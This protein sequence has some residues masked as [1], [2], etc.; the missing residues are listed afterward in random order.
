MK[1]DGVWKLS[2]AARDLKEIPMNIPGDI[3]ATLLE[4]KI[5]PDPFYATNEEPIQWVGEQEWE[6]EH[7][8]EVKNISNYVSYVLALELVDCFTTIYINDKEALQT[9]STFKFY[10]TDIHKFLKEGKN[11][12]RVVFHNAR[13][14]ASKRF[15]NR[16]PNYFSYSENNRYPF[17][18]Y[19]RKPQFQAGWDWG[20]AIVNM[21]IYHTVNLIPIPKNGY[22]LV[23][24]STE[25]L[26]GDNDEITLIV[27]ID[28]HNYVKTD[29][30]VI[31]K[32]KFD[33]EEK[34]V[35]IPANEPGEHRYN[36]KF[37]TKGKERWNV[38]GY[39]KQTLYPLTATLS[40]Q[41]I[42]KKI[43]IRKLIVDC[44]DDEFGTSL[45]FVVNGTIINAL[46]ANF[47]PTDSLPSR[48]TK[49]RT[50][51]LM[52]DMIESNMNIVRVWGGVAILMM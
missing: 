27:D 21:G 46:G 47:I 10:R 51:Q 50:Y 42:T 32:V 17:M 35:S 15:Y 11:T 20:P 25:Q 1:L 43:G 33:N 5:I 7:E 45:Q 30:P 49:E 6:I 28:V 26:Y 44:H 36:V 14:E 22:D 3:H 4:K 29:A 41:T 37:S 24:L 31:L 48:A 39:G 16:L 52:Q 38:H 2:C 8:F 40:D 18:N 9:T 19:I 12:I 23:E 13:K 34:E